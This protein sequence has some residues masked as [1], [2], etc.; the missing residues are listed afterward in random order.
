[1]PVPSEMEITAV[2]GAVEISIEL[3]VIVTVFPVPPK[4]EMA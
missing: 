4:F 2:P 3:T 1:V